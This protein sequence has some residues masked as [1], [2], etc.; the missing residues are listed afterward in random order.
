[1]RPR[2]VSTLGVKTPRKV[3]KRWAGSC[4]D[5]SVVM[6][7]HVADGSAAILQRYTSRPQRNSMGLL[8]CRVQGECG[9]R[10]T[11]R[12]R[13]GGRPEVGEEGEEGGGKRLGGPAD[14]FLEPDF[15]FYTSARASS[16][17][18]RNAA[19]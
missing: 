7:P 9:V 2:I 16:P 1:M 5:A 17:E 4:A 13:S 12:A 19:K 15:P 18:M 14:S 8:G 3:P 10:G 11:D 6:S